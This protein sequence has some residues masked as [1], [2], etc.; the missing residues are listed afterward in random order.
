MLLSTFFF[1]IQ[2]VKERA[3]PFP[4]QPPTRDDNSVSV[5]QG[6]S[7]TPGAIQAAFA[8]GQGI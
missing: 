7:A 6:D 2:R 3:I 5:A 8:T 4:H 1:M